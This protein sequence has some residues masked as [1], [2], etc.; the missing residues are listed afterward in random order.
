MFE[1][2]RRRFPY[3]FISNSVSATWKWTLGTINRKLISLLANF[4]S[5]QESSFAMNSLSSGSMS[6]KDLIP[7]LLEYMFMEGIK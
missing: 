7:S 6:F 4:L 1:R 3:A 2:V 5:P